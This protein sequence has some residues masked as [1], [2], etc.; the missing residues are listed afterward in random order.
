MLTM[1][2]SRELSDIDVIIPISPCL[3]EK[4][5]AL[6]VFSREFENTLFFFLVCSSPVVALLSD[7]NIF[8]VTIIC[9]VL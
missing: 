8:V 3:L 5:K 4:V 1:V 7:F 9:P 6:L 2:L